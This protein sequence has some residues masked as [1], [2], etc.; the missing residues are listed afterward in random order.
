MNLQ[1][2]WTSGA[3]ESFLAITEYLTKTWGGRI[4][5]VFVSD[6]LHTLA[7]LEKFPG[8]GVVEVRWSER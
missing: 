4:A 8:G 1:S 6:V 2:F 3:E 5:D 7:L